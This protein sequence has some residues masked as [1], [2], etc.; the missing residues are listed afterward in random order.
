RHAPKPVA[1]A[2]T[3]PRRL[4]VVVFCQ[5]LVGIYGG[6]FGAA[7]GIITLAFLSL[8]ASTDIHGMN[9]IKNLLAALVNGAAS[10]YF[11]ASGLVG[12]RAA[13]VLRSGVLV[14]G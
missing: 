3:S 12:R 1:G 5:L 2:P 10:I 8:I 9:G 11:I 14:G 6:Y 4:A 7:M 13:L